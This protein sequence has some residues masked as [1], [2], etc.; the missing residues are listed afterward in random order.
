MSYVLFPHL[1]KSWSLSAQCCGSLGYGIVRL[2]SKDPANSVS[3]LSRKPVE[4][5]VQGV[6][7]YACDITDIDKL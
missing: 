2:L 3:V 7:Y 6:S 4:P 5:R 1:P